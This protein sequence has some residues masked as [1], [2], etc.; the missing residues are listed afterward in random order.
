MSLIEMS[1]SG[2]V[3]ILVI[4]AVRAALKDRLP[5]RTFAVL[6]MV[7]LFRLLVPFSVPSAWSV[8]TFLP[9]VVSD[10]QNLAPDLQNV[11][12]GSENEAMDFE[13]NSQPSTFS[14]NISEEAPLETI[15]MATEQPEAKPFNWNM[16]WAAGFLISL[17]F[18]AWIYGRCFREFQM[19]LPVEKGI[20]GNWRETHPLRRKLSIRQSDQIASPISYGV[21]RPVILLSKSVKSGDRFRLRYVLEHE[22][23]HIQYFDAA[24]KLLMVAA[25]CVH[26]FNPFV[27]LMYVFFNRDLELACDE[28]VVR[29]FGEEEKAAYAMALIEMEEEKS[30][31]LP[32]GNSFSKNAIEERIGAIMKI[33]KITPLAKGMSAALVC[34]ITLIFMTSCGTYGEAEKIQVASPQAEAVG[35]QVTNEKNSVNA[36]SFSAV[37]EESKKGSGVIRQTAYDPISKSAE[38]DGSLNLQAQKTPA[39][40]ESVVGYDRKE[41]EERI[42]ALDQAIQEKQDELAQIDTL[43]KVITDME[44][45]LGQLVDQARLLQ[46]VEEETGKSTSQ[47]RQENEKQRVKLENQIEGKGTELERL[48]ESADTLVEEIEKMREEKESLRWM[49]S[50]LERKTFFEENYGEYGVRYDLY[51]HSLYMDTTPNRQ[52]IRYFIDEENGGVLWAA[53][54]GEVIEEVIYDK[55]GKRVALSGEKVDKAEDKIKAIEEAEAEAAA[56]AAEDA[57]DRAKEAVITAGTARIESTEYTTDQPYHSAAYMISISDAFEEYEKFGLSYD[58]KSDYLMYQ[59]NTVGYFKDEIKRGVY[60]RLIE[61]SGKLGIIVNRDDSGEITEFTV[62]PF[63]ESSVSDSSVQEE[64]N[65][66][67]E[68]DQGLEISAEASP[69]EATYDEGDPDAAKSSVPKEYAKL[70]VKLS[71]EKNNLWMYKGK[72]VAVIYDKD[73][74][75]FTNDSISEKNAVYLEVIRDKKDR[76]TGL[77]E[78]TKKEMQKLIRE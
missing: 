67:Y 74:A 29:R 16:L 69:Y 51:E 42:A 72:G 57:A 39:V 65:A 41:I 11:A 76:V 1:V 20:L 35:T 8:Y 52:Y 12:P 77:K 60:T 15:P 17:A 78:V 33:K 56:Q 5:K 34:G 71:D 66:V 38:K 50:E 30:G 54:E 19:S 61:G 25:L 31:L 68:Q 40:E 55:N 59:D 37:L 24:V 64:G 21:W 75:I 43:S 9:N 73:H 22:Y 28:T 46:D 23:V 13:Q 48:N 36:K 32:L 4:L 47:K 58:K 63:D 6:W 26:W 14:A 27:Y 70:G 7:A 3:L 53:N 10:L 45:Q 62:F 18:F 49:K 2:T 44:E